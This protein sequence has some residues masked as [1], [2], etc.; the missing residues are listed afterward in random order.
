MSVQ[1]DLILLTWNHL[2]VTRRC[3]GSLFQRTDFP[4]RLILVDN[5]SDQKG[6]IEYLN[7]V[8]PD[9]PIKSVVF[10]RNEE[11]LGFSRGM[12]RGLRYALEHQP[13]RHL[14]VIS[15]DVVMTDGWLSELIRIA[16]RLPEI[17]LVNPVSTNF[18]FYPPNENKINEYALRLT[19]HEKGKW[20]EL[21]SCIGFCFLIKR[22]VLEGVGLFDEVYGMAYYEDADL[23]KRAQA[24]GYLC[25]LAQGSYVYHEQGESF[26]KQQQKSQL[27]LKNEKIFYSRWNMSG[28]ERICWILC[29]KRDKVDASIFKKMRLLANRFNKIK[30]IYQDQAIAEK[31]PNHWNIQSVC[32]GKTPA[33]FFIGAWGYLLLKKKK[34]DR[35]FVD[36]PG[37]IGFLKNSQRRY[38]RELQL[39][40]AASQPC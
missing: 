9:G 35:I 15:N 19:R 26:G 22:E 6:V 14:C 20:Q 29:D 25:A 33:P 32:L 13:A 27:F 17:G 24:A 38:Q 40:T 12:N 39:D 5:G 31:I 10:L 16:D 18:G 21:G 37:L 7:A 8:R 23:S 28:P 1:C 11:D 3:L 34:F 30:V 2:E 4:C 36:R